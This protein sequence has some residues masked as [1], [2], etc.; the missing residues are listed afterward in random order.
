M[1]TKLSENYVFGSFDFKYFEKSPIYIE[2]LDVKEQVEGLKY[3]E[4]YTKIEQ[5]WG[6]GRLSN[7]NSVTFFEDSYLIDNIVRYKVDFKK[8]SFFR[9]LTILL[10]S[11]RKTLH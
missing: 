6:L 8:H 4:S 5:N 9:T 3:Q 1:R 2:Y 11:L 10:Q 7:E